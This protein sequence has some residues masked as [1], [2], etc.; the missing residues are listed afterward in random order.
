[1]NLGRQLKAMQPP[2]LLLLQEWQLLKLLVSV[3]VG[4]A[5][6]PSEASRKISTLWR[7]T[8]TRPALEIR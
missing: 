7:K 3:V 4:A 1:L 8:L 2:L 5:S 6:R